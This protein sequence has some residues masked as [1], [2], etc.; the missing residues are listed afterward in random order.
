ML[1]ENF[2]TQIDPDLNYFWD[3]EDP[4]LKHG[5]K[6]ISVSEFNKSCDPIS[7][8]YIFACN[9]RSFEKNMDSFL[10]NFEN[11]SKLPS[12]I[13]TSETW[14][15]T[16]SVGSLPGYAAYHVVRE[17]RRSGGVSIFVQDKIKSRQI[18]N[19]SIVDISIELCCVEVILD[20][21]PY[22][23][24]GVYR[25]HSGNIEN[26]SDSLCTAISDP[27]IGSRPVIVLGV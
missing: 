1:I 20:E 3:G 18:P 25:P 12:I 26:F 10:A 22:I 11:S 21:T 19:I 24:F 17:G 15:K 6:Y 16:N 27:V 5:S 14:L 2:D 9:I 13:V 23:I 7:N 8:Y 4:Q